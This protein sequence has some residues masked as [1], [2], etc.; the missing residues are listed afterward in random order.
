MVKVK[1]VAR[2]ASIWVLVC[3]TLTTLTASGIAMWSFTR[4]RNT[5]S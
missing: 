1:T 3:L 5:F 4:L 2:K